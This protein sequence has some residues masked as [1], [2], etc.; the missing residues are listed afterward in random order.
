M[1]ELCLHGVGID[2]LGADPEFAGACRNLQHTNVVHVY[3]RTLYRLQIPIL[4][5]DAYTEREREIFFLCLLGS[6]EYFMIIFITINIK[7]FSM[8][9]FFYIFMSEI[10][11]NYH[12]Y[13]CL[14]L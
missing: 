10:D 1:R 6:K 7:T 9:D 12:L 5:S 11:A 14:S 4:T 8:Q 13:L 2:D 3:V